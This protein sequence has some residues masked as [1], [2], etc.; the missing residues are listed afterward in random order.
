MS[1]EFAVHWLAEAAVKK[2]NKKL[3]EGWWRMFSLSLSS[4]RSYCRLSCFLL[5]FAPFTTGLYGSGH[6][7]FCCCCCCCWRGVVDHWPRL[8]F[9]TWV[10]LKKR[11]MTASERGAHVHLVSIYST[12]T[13]TLSLLGDRG[14]WPRLHGTRERKSGMEGGGLFL[15][16]LVLFCYSFSPFPPLSF[17]LRCFCY[18]LALGMR[19]CIN[20]QGSSFRFAAQR[21]WTVTHTHTKSF[22]IFIVGFYSQLYVH[23]V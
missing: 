19:Q 18:S 7:G 4:F 8:S 23:N 20:R 22:L 16:C 9:C 5:L 15:F 6:C 21:K 13:R 11:N 17:P 3:F 10:R 2:K 1:V 12:G 14:C